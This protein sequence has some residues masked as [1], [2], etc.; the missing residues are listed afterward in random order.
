MDSIY[1][2][3]TSIFP[4]PCLPA[5]IDDSEFVDI[6]AAG[7]AFRKYFD[8]KTGKTHDGATYH[9]QMQEMLDAA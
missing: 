3:D 6:T 5:N 1:K 4:S 2:M 8:P 9:K 7:D